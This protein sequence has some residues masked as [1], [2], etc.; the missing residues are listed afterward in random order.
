MSG[1]LTDI[2][3]LDL[4]RVLAGPFCTMVLADLGAEVIKLERPDTG[5]DSRTFGPF[6]NQESAY[7]ISINRGKKSI[8]LDLK[9]PRSKE[10]FRDLVKNVDVLVENFKPGVLDRLGLGYAEL[11]QINPRLIYA[12]SSGFG[13]TGPYSKRPAYDLIIQGMGGLMSITGPDAAHPTKVG[14]S[15]AD[16]FA[17]VFCA[18]GI[19]SALHSRHITGRGQMVDVAMLDCMVAILENAVARFAASGQD[20]H[21]IGN[22]H[23]SI[24]PFSTVQTADG[25]MNIAVGNDVLWARFCDVIGHPELLADERFTT[26]P[27]RIEHRLELEQILAGIMN[28]RSTADWLDRL[29][30]V[31]IPSGPINT[32]SQVF[33]DPQVLA[34]NML[35]ELTHPKAGPMKVPGIPIKLSET[36]GEIK[37]PS[38]D[39]GEH[40]DQILEQLLGY[41]PETIAKLRAEGVL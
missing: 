32:I 35:V 39:L 6:I 19:L 17:G 2:R 26:N 28:D 7:F 18:I 8:T 12:S 25:A 4:T 13:Q 27:R 10:V 33:A 24:A 20:P 11:S 5:D 29:Q 3:V 41:S 22:S 9:H 38:P 34:R 36:P 1:P 40:T 37:G 16:I 30:K 23:P 14:S 21:P 31:E 15:I